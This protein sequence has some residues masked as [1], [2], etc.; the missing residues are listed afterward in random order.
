MAAMRKKARRQATA[1]LVIYAGILNFCRS[2]LLVASIS[3][4]S[5][6]PTGNRCCYNASHDASIVEA[7]RDRHTKKMRSPRRSKPPTAAIMIHI[8]WDAGEGVPSA[9]AEVGLL[10]L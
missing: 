2:C 9:G 6:S 4:P 1:Y 8:M 5:V 3:T 10:G 7:F